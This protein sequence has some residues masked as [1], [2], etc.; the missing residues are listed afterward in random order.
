MPKEVVTFVLLGLSF[1]IL[2]DV[3]R[4]F[5]FIFTSSKIQFVID[6][7]YFVVISITYFIFLLAYNNGQVRAYYFTLSLLGF[8]FYI[9]TVFRL[10][11]HG[12]KFVALHLRSLARKVAKSSKKVLQFIRGV[13]YNSIVLR[14]KPLRKKKKVGNTDESIFS[15]NKT[16]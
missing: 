5:R 7:L 10:T 9:F 15:E 6:F 4:F 3:F 8:F 12:E 2:Y 14:L 13:Y 11:E 16:E 1:G